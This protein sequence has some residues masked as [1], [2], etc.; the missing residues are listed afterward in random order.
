MRT[1][2]SWQQYLAT[3]D[4]GGIQLHQYATASFRADV[5][6]GTVRLAVETDYPWSGEI[7]V[8]VEETPDR[9]WTLSLRVPAWTRSATLSIGANEPA[10]VADGTRTI[11]ETRV[12]QAGD[13]VVLALDMPVRVTEP[14]PRI[15]AIR[16]CVAFERGP[17]VFCIETADLPD[18]TDLEAV[19]VSP[20]VEPVVVARDD[21]PGTPI[22]ITLPAI[23]SATGKPIDVGAVPY[24][25]WAHRTVGGM[26]VWVPV[27]AERSDRSG[28]ARDLTE[29]RSGVR[30]PA[31]RRAAG[32]SAWTPPVERS[33]DGR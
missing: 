33:I 19:V 21:V 31:P 18:G 9:P 8:T 11:H 17:I 24:A 2:S 14:D 26:R 16:G 6:G 28:H 20:S 27:R 22:G 5:A 32:R 13:R 4:E 7:A 29:E 10:P 23:D 1:L 30:R 25:S 12:W 15:D 3:V